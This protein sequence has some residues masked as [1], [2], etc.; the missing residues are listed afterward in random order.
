M[1]KQELHVDLHEWPIHEA[2]AEGDSGKIRQ[3]VELEK[4][5]DKN[6]DPANIMLQFKRQ[7]SVSFL[8]KKL[9]MAK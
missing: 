1:M 2:A 8:K 4:N 3:L 6:A 5:K 9:I 7:L